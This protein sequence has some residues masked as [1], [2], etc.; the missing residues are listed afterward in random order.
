M[1]T[2]L[3][4]VANPAHSDTRTGFGNFVLGAGAFL[5]SFLGIMQ[6]ELDVTHV[7]ASQLDVEVKIDQTLQFN[8]ENFPVPTGF[9]GE[10]VISDDVSALVRRREMT[11]PQGRHLGQPEELCCLD[12]AMTGN[13]H[14]RIIHKH[15][16]VEAESLDAVC[17]LSDLFTRVRACI[18]LRWFKLV[19][20]GHFDVMA[21]NNAWAFDSGTDCRTDD[22]RS[23]RARFIT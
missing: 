9:F 22:F 5:P 23:A 4:N 15:R 3:P 19:D 6:D 11:E 17:D 2:E 20:R 18:C 7:E 13:N 12:P 16:I 8:G 1:L 21:T 14:V 10:P